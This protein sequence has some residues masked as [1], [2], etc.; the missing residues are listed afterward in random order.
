MNVLLTHMCTN[1]KTYLVL[2]KEVLGNIIENT[3]ARYLPILGRYVYVGNDKTYYVLTEE[4]LGNIIKMHV[5][6]TYL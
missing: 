1:D 2:P 6:G 4:V 3:C 5:L